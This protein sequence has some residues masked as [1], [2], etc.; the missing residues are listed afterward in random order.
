LD[1]KWSFS[2]IAGGVPI[3]DQSQADYQDFELPKD[4]ANDL[5]TK[6]L[7][8]AGISIREGDVFKFGQIEEQMQNQE[9]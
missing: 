8:Y 7:Q 1:P 5:I 9:E 2:T 3:F 6:I 4:D